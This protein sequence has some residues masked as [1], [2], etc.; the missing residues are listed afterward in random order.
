M[1]TTVTEGKLISET[2]DRE[3]PVEVPFEKFKKIFETKHY[4]MLYTDEK[5]VYVL[6]KGAFEK[7]REEEFLPYIRN[8]IENNK[9]RRI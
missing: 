4:Y 2:S 7:G 6:K 9:S 1:T 5:M 8:Q 3:T